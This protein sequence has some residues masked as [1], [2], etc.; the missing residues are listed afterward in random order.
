MSY[1]EATIESSSFANRFNEIAD[2]SF[3]DVMNES[4]HR[5]RSD[6]FSM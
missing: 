6:K 5:A 4:V 3:E 1:N 2:V